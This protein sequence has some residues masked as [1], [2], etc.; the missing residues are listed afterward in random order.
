MKKIVIGA[1][2][3][4][5]GLCFWFSGLYLA[6]SFFEKDINQFSLPL[7]LV[8][9][10]LIPLVLFLFFDLILKISALFY[11]HFLE[12]IQRLKILKE[13]FITYR[14]LGY[15]KLIRE[16]ITLLKRPFEIKSFSM[17]GIKMVTPGPAT[18]DIGTS[19]MLIVG[20]FIVFLVAILPVLI[21]YW[22]LHLDKLRA[23]LKICTFIF[24]MGLNLIYF[25]KNKSEFKSTRA[26]IG[27]L[28]A[29]ATLILFFL[30]MIFD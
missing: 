13:K 17:S 29:E 19:E 10:I 15:K 7:L 23:G 14:K 28:A 3:T 5:Y 24:L 8:V 18:I 16:K 30:E 26:K 27:H 9:A 21:I 4:F 22:I 1:I 12:A 20:L 11:Y 2:I 25:Q 6:S